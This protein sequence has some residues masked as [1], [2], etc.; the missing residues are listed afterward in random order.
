[1][2]RFN[3]LPKFG[4]AGLT[5]IE[6]GRRATRVRAALQNSNFD[7]PPRKITDGSES[8]RPSYAQQ[9]EAV[10][11]QSEGRAILSADRCG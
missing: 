11:H 9:M 10:R 3:G 6:V 7:F 5:E 8:E 4:L 1:M 2:T